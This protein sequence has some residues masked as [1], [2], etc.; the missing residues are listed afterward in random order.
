MST[1]CTNCDAQF[2]ITLCSHDEIPVC[3]TCRP[4]MTPVIFMPSIIPPSIEVIPGKT[5]NWEEFHAP[6]TAIRTDIGFWA[7]EDHRQNK[8]E[9]EPFNTKMIRKV[10]VAQHTSDENDSEWVLVFE[11]F[12]TVCVFFKAYCASFDFT[13]QSGGTVSVADN[14]ETFWDE[15]LDIETRRQL[16]IEAVKTPGELVMVG[17]VHPLI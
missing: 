9:I 8:I 5:V 4:S 10:F 2:D 12:D 14:F 15:C 17:Q 3:P 13:C 11:R 7:I 1:F 6:L 16:S